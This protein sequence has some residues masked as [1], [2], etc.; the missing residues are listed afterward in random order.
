MPQL[1]RKELWVPV[2][3][4]V[5]KTVS[6]AYWAGAFTNSPLTT[7]GPPQKPYK[8]CPAGLAGVHHVRRQNC[9]LQRACPL[10]DSRHAL[11]LK[12]LMSFSRGLQKEAQTLRKLHEGHPDT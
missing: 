5:S 1:T 3:Y 10:P 2:V 12:V 9:S 4:S 6:E 8:S 7:Q 11:Q